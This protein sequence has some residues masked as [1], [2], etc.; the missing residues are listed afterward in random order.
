MWIFPKRQSSVFSYHLRGHPKWCTRSK[1]NVKFVNCG[2]VL[3]SLWVCV[4]TNIGINLSCE[5][6]LDS[7]ISSR[8]LVAVGAGVCPGGLGA[9]A[10][11]GASAFLLLRRRPGRLR[12]PRPL[13]PSPLALTTLGTGDCRPRSMLEL[14]PGA[15]APFFFYNYIV[16]FEIRH[17]RHQSNTR[18]RIIWHK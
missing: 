12:P 18:A 10:G 1:N 4:A 3:I 15:Q 14:R 16:Q 17:V 8:Q 9:G 5:C 6:F 7:S 11:T 2:S 13:L